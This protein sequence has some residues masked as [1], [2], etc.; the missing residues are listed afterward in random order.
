MLR[1]YGPSMKRGARR[2][3]IAGGILGGVS[4]G[5]SE[6]GSFM[7]GAFKGA[8]IGAGVGMTAGRYG[9]MFRRARMPKLTGRINAGRA[10]VVGRSNFGAYMS[11][12]RPLLT[13]GGGGMRGQW[14]YRGDFQRAPVRGARFK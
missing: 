1:G 10:T 5:M 9:E 14:E 4:G 7:G 13:A 12:N 11:S 2:G 3:A 8:L 6:D